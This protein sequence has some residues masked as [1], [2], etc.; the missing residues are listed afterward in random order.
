MDNNKGLYLH[1]HKSFMQHF[2]HVYLTVKS[3]HPVGLAKHGKAYKRYDR[4]NANKLNNK[5]HNI[6]AGHWQSVSSQNICSF[7]IHPGHPAR[8]H[9]VICT[10]KWLKF[11]VLCLSQR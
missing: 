11:K 8:M 4:K 5:I 10:G 1:S 3:E 7:R 9:F 6:C 2:S